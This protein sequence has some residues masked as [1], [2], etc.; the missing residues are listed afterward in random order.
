MTVRRVGSRRIMVDGVEYLW[1]FR[2]RPH[3]MDWDGDTGFVVTV[4]RVERTGSVLILCSGH[5]HPTVA[6]LWG[7]PVV[8]VLPSEVAAAIKQALSAGW[9]SE[10]RGANFSLALSTTVPVPAPVPRTESN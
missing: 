5:R 1:R 3:R 7:S 9:R 6:R 4:Q 8:S 10:V 2:H